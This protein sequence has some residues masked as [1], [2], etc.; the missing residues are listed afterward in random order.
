MMRWPHFTGSGSYAYATIG[1]RVDRPDDEV[2]GLLS[3][4]SEDGG[5]PSVK[6]AAVYA[7]GGGLCPM[8]IGLVEGSGADTNGPPNAGDG[9]FALKYGP[10]AE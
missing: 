6:I 3:R 1:D 10:T 9:V 4:L 5:L 2:P 7:D 8:I